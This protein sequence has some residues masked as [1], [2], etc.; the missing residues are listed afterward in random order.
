[1]LLAHCYILLTE[2]SD[3]DDCPLDSEDNRSTEN[4]IYKY[5][6]KSNNF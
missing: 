5:K 1:M 4:V 3:K 2:T 6:N